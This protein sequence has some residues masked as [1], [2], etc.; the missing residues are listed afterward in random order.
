MEA[1]DNKGGDEDK[2]AMEEDNPRPGCSN[3]NNNPTE[4]A[5]DLEKK[6]KQENVNE[7]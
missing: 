6:E 1:R 4:E 2:E 7:N 3:E 5:K